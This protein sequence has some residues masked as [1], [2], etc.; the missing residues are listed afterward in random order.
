MTEASRDDLGDL[1]AFALGRLEGP[2]RA[3]LERRLAADPA[4]RRELD[5]LRALVGLLALVDEGRFDDPGGPPDHLEAAV[6]RAVARERTAAARRRRARRLAVGGSIAAALLLVALV[7]GLVLGRGGPSPTPF[8]TAAGD[9]SGA[10]ALEA[11]PWGTEIELEVGGLSRGEVYWL[12]LSD[13]DGN[14]T[15]AGTFRGSASR[16]KL[17]LASALPYAQAARIWVTD[18]DDAVVLDSFLR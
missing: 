7:L 15:G 8:E 1:A 6:V 11:R 2:E 4:L 13:A 12:W 3:E 9:V 16:Q 18:E 5:D 10:F 17:V 14:R